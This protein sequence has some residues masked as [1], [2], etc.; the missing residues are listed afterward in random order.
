MSPVDVIVAIKFDISGFEFG[1]FT[2]RFNHLN[3]VKR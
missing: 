2:T 3:D 1:E